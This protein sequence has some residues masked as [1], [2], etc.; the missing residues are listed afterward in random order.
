MKERMRRSRVEIIGEL[1]RPIVAAR[2]DGDKDLG[3]SLQSISP[4][5]G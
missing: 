2:G 5:N 4:K 3:V 1:S